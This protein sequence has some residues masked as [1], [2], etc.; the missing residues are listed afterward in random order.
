[1]KG[2]FSLSTDGKD[3]R[4]VAS[5]KRGAALRWGRRKTLRLDVL[6]ESVRGA[7]DALLAA[8]EQARAREAA[9]DG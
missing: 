7:I 9:T 5:G 3:P 4:L 6:P 1:M 2:A 8:E